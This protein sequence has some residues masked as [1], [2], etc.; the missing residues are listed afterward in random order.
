[1]RNYAGLLRVAES[2]AAKLVVND[3][4]VASICDQSVYFPVP[5]RMHRSD[6]WLTQS[7]ESWKEAVLKPSIET[8]LV[9]T[10]DKIYF[11]KRNRL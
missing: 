4:L 11:V 1:M 8:I 3:D 7:L 9:L 10:V 5:N 6:D 2:F